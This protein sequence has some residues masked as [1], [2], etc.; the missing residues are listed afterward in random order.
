MTID[1]TFDID[2]P[3]QLQ[4]KKSILPQIVALLYKRVKSTKIT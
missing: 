4:I 3:P 2:Y 1:L